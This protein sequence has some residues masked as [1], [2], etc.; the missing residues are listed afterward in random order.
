MSFTTNVVNIGRVQGNELTLNKTNVSKQHAKL[1]YRDGVFTVA[2]LHSTNGTYVNKRRIQ[3]ATRL[4]E[5][6]RLFI[7]DYV[8]KIESVDHPPPLSDSEVPVE[9]VDVSAS[10]NAP[11]DSTTTRGKMPQEVGLLSRGI[12]FRASRLIP[13]FR[14]HPRFPM[15]VLMQVP[16]G[17]RG[18]RGDIP[19]LPKSC[20]K[21]LGLR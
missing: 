21:P 3:E 13:R 8:I 16:L 15:R 1:T 12:A 6:D 4:N 7:G 10:S 20:S 19:C 17:P 9:V 11:A 5:G 14:R 18:L 2:D